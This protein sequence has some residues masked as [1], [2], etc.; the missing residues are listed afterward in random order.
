MRALREGRTIKSSNDAVE[1]V[2]NGKMAGRLGGK[3]FLPQW[4][5]I[6]FP[7]KLFNIGDEAFAGT[8][9][10]EVH[11]LKRL[12]RIQRRCFTRCKDLTRVEFSTN[13]AEIGRDAFEW[14][15]KL[16]KLVPYG[17]L[18]DYDLK[19][20]VLFTMGCFSETPLNTEFEPL[21]IGD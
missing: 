20:E 17:D 7:P 13:L 21:Y 9:L 18:E 19:D 16:T 4:I 6:D 5:Q 3:R 10:T 8:G 1:L 14:C 12:A 2:Q 15:G 11:L